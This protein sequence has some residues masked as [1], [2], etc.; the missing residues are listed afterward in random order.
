M[1]HTRIIESN[2]KGFYLDRKGNVLNLS[3][4]FSPH[5]LVFNGHIRT[6]LR[7]GQPTNVLELPNE[8]ANLQIKEIFELATYIDS[9]ELWKSQF[10]QVY[11][12]GKK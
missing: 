10:V 4:R 1:G 8:A 12:N 11:L 9:D 2:G 7:V 6:D 3:D 5:V